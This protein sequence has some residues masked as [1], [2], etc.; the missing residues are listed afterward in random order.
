MEPAVGQPYDGQRH[1][2]QTNS[3]RRLQTAV[4]SPL[5]LKRWDGTHSA[6]HSSAALL[7]DLLA[8][9]PAEVLELRIVPL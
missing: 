6:L 2:I 4:R 5:G 1:R 8:V 7:I 9:I 3:K